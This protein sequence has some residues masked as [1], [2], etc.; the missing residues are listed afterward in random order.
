MWRRSQIELK[1]PAQ[2]ELMRAAG[3][4]VAVTLVASAQAATAGAS[5]RSINDVAA[6]VIAD[7]D[8]QSSFLG[9]Q[10][11]PASICISVNDEIIH[12][13]PGEHILQSGDL[14]SIDAG[15]I[16]SG[17]HG[18]AAVSFI[19]PESDVLLDVTN[20]LGPFPPSQVTVTPVGSSSASLLL[21]NRTKAAL[22]GGIAAA[23]VGARLS[24]IG[25]AVEESLVDSGHG[26]V[27]D[28]VG[29]G[30]G[31]QMHMP[32]NVSN[33]GP[34]GRGPILKEGMVLAIEPMVMMS[35]S[36]VTVLADNWTVVTDSGV[37]AAHWEHTV[38]ITASG[39]RVLTLPLNPEPEIHHG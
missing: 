13:I 7:R 9:Y 32:P 6:R 10:G 29:H 21:M 33:V 4:V 12:G 35:P 36:E 38:A 8:A 20:L 2:L 1:T 11:Y 17:W 31:T 23:V 28:F 19:V 26:I 14:V 15:A 30:I 27:T 5:T 18:D 24:D 39:P 37:Q 34:A 16:V 3:A 22:W 25:A